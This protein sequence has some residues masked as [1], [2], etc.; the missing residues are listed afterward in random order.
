LTKEFDVKYWNDL[1]IN[2][3]SPW[4]MGGISA[5][6]KEYFDQIKN[7]KISI[8]IPGA[9]NAYEAEYLVSS[10]FEN[11]Y[12]CDFAEEPLKN[13]SDRC[14]KI[15]K[16]NLLQIDFFEINCQTNPVT[17]SSVEGQ[18]D[19]IIE[20]TFFCALH[21][22]L[23]K[24]YF[25]KMHSLLKPGGKLV[26]LLFN[27]PALNKDKPPFGG[28]QEEYRT[29]FESLFKINVFGTCRNSIK[30]RAGRELFINLEKIS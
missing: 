19:L 1:Y 21:P 24:K 29:Y 30:P 23:R 22:S 10:G 2:K 26:G 28:T 27:D 3:D 9:G 15:K 13:L 4:D 18:F 14:K 25:E 12:V 6:L 11:V 20:Q 16:E 7:K 8:L 17:L 5:P